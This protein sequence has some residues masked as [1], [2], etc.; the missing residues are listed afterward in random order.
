MDKAIVIANLAQV[1]YYASILSTEI[2]KDPFDPDKVT[3]EL[4]SIQTV[5]LNAMKEIITDPTVTSSRLQQLE[6]GVSFAVSNV[7]A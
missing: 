5:L 7:P 4:F 1:G 3:G 2:V 6:R